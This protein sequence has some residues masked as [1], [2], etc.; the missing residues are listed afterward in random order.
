VTWKPIDIFKDIDEKEEGNKEE[1]KQ[2]STQSNNADSFLDIPMLITIE[3]EKFT[4]VAK[5]VI[6]NLTLFVTEIGCGDENSE[7]VINT[8]PANQFITS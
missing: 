3:Y 8:S 2:N 5:C 6:S 4:L 7:F 1:D